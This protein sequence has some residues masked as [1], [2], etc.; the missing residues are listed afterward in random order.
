MRICS[1][2][3]EESI[4]LTQS[5]HDEQVIIALTESLT[6]AEEEL[7]VLAATRPSN[8]IL[9]TTWLRMKQ[10]TQVAVDRI[11][12]LKHAAEAGDGAHVRKMIERGTN[13]HIRSRIADKLDLERA[14]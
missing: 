3:Y 11:A 4:E 5:I 10:R 7:E 8:P 13:C 1:T 14:A 12:D 6:E 2:N 9:R